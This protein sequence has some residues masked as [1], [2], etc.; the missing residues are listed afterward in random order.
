MLR[1]GPSARQVC[2]LEAPTRA[3]GGRRGARLVWSRSRLC[4]SQTR[5]SGLATSMASAIADGKLGMGM[6][7]ETREMVDQAIAAAKEKLRRNGAGGGGSAPG[8]EL[9][10][11]QAL[12]FLYER[13]LDFSRRAV[14]SI[15][16]MSPPPRFVVVCGDLV[17]QY[18]KTQDGPVG[19]RRQVADFKEIFSHV[20]EDIRLLCLCGNHGGSD[21][22]NSASIAQFRSASATTTLR[23]CL[24]AYSSSRST[25]GCTKTRRTRLQR[26]RRR[27]NGCVGSHPRSRAGAGK[28]RQRRSNAAVVMCWSRLWTTPRLHHS[29]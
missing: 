7:P 11:A 19:Q 28:K 25:P 15:N 12:S 29:T 18:P 20:R 26:P 8:S 16:A 17:N 22:L 9:D 1:A 24:A 2:R 13:E 10:Y 27:T 5:S 14:A 23:S 3:A 6:T 21:R 4:S